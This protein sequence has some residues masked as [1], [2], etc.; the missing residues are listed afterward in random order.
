MDGLRRLCFTTNFIGSASSLKQNHL[1]RF[2]S[3]T[4]LVT[5]RTVS[6]L[7]QFPLRRELRL[8]ESARAR[9]H[10]VRV[11]R[12]SDYNVTRARATA[13]SSPPLRPRSP[14]H[15]FPVTVLECWRTLPLPGADDDA[16]TRVSAF[17]KTRSSSRASDNRDHR[18]YFPFS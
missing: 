6:N 5:V 9:A 13:P 17:L 15:R 18:H 3:S 1:N 4:R 16:L 14:R 11:A 2:L 8:S 7:L 10:R 12:H